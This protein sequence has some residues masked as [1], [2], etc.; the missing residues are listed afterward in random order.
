MASL[1]PYTAAH[2]FTLEELADNRAGKLHPRQVQRHSN[3]GF[4]C[5]VFFIVL[6]VLV[7]AGGLGGAAFFY[8]SLRKPVDRV[9]MNGVYVLAAA[10]V[11]FSLCFVAAT[12]AQFRGVARQRAAYLGAP[13]VVEGRV[14][15]VVIQ[16]RR[17]HDRFAYRIEGLEF[18]VPEAGWKLSENGGRYRVFFVGR[19]L[20]SIEPLL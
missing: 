2:G 14:A 12:I 13:S 10:G 1:E 3:A 11:F 5:A 15:K 18:D 9:D 16:Q 20:L 8:D 17:M 4:G 7:L 19:D 6:A